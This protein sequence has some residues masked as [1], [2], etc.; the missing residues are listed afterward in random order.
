MRR[1]PIALSVLV[2]APCVALSAPGGSFAGAPPAGQGPPPGAVPAVGPAVA[3]PSTAP[4]PAVSVG[5]GGG[6][7]SVD[8][9]ASRIGLEVLQKG[10]NAVDAAVATAAALGVTEPFSAGVGGG[11]YFVYYDAESGQVQTIDGRETA[12]QAITRDAF[13]DP[14]TGEPYTFT[15]DLVTSGVAVG[16]P[17]T[18]ATW[19]TALSRW[20]TRSLAQVLEPSARLADTGF[21]I[22]QTFRSQTNDNRKR[23]SAFRTTKGLYLR[24]GR[25]P[26]VGERFRNPDLARTYRAFGRDPLLFTRGSLPR[27]IAVAVRRPPIAPGGTDLP[28]PPGYLT[29]GDF[30]RYRPSVQAPSHTSYRGLDVVGMRPSSSGGTTVGEALNILERDD[31]SAMSEGDFLHHYLEAGALAFADRG[32]YVGDARFVDVPVNRLLDQRFA[33]ERACGL[34]PETAATKPVPAGDVDDYDGQCSGT[35]ATRP[36]SQED[37]ENVSTTHLT[38]ADRWGNVV[39]YTLTIEQTGGS[40]IVVPGRGFL[41]NNE[42]TDFS[43]VYDAK[44][45]NRLQRG[46]RPR[47]SM[48]PTIVLRDGKP[49]IAVGSPGGSTIITTVLQVLLNR[50]DRGMTLAEAVAAPRASPRNTPTVSAEPPFLDRYQTLL[51]GYGHD[52]VPSGDTLTSAAE[53]GAVTAIEFSPGGR[54]TVVAEPTRRGGGSARVVTPG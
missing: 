19:R 51:E 41:L 25:S 4:R 15:P 10:G 18:P 42:L 16:V 35:A 6:V 24:G 50:L 26:V 40:G 23:F 9:D 39:S 2:L 48:A 3:G 44:D 5:S 37:N 43:L 1:R 27:E 14:D 11:G 20:G 36:T 49:F 54:L 46:K 52:L 38:T 22:D 34:D 8:A 29:T 45:P 53:I 7:T 32:A 30:Q 13:L 47:S 31:L 28:V 12:P 33:D 17:G 21:V